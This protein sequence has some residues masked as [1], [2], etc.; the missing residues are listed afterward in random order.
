LKQVCTRP[1]RVDEPGQRGDVRPLELLQAAP[2]EDQLRELVRQRQLLE[3]FE[4]RRLR[5]GLRRPADCLGPHAKAIE[6]DF[7]QLLGRVD[8]ELLARQLVHASREP[9]QLVIEPF[10]LR[11]KRAA[12][13]PDSGALDGDEDWNQR[14]L[15]LVVDALELVL[16]Q[17]PPQRGRELEREIRPLA[18]VVERAVGGHGGKRDSLHAAAADVFLAQRLVAAV[19]DRE[20]LEWVRRSVRVEQVARDHHVRVETAKLDAV[21]F[22][23]DGV[24]LQVVADLA[25]RVVFE[26]GLERGKRGL[27][28]QTG[29]RV[30]V[31]RPE[32]IAARRSARERHVPGVPCARRKREPDDAASHRG[33]TVDQ[34]AEAESAGLRERRNQGVEL[35]HRLDGPVV[36]A[37]RL[38]GW[39]VF[40]DERSEPE[41]G[42]QLEASLPRCPTVADPVGIEL[43]RHVGAD[44]GELAALPGILGMRQQAFPIAFV[45]DL[46]RVLEQRFERSVGGNQ[47]ARAFLADTRHAFDVVDRIAH[48]RDDVDHL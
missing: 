31:R 1:V 3:H 39:R 27:A 40:E 24:E 8:V 26:H 19:L 32:Q 15:Q 22:E 2:L 13:D 23:D 18:R 30:A 17:Q 42:E 21:A 5:L 33:R 37:D 16:R 35:A 11:G 28:V 36:L 6:Q 12:V 9:R 46:R 25:H 14:M 38:R 34:H 44:A 43:D 41:A 48:E 45:A 20:I 29:C 7:R 10:G 4:R 47:V